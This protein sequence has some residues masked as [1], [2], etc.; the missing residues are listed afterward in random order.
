MKELVA[1]AQLFEALVEHG[2]QLKPQDS[3]HSGKHH[4]RFIGRMSRFF[5][6]CFPVNLLHPVTPAANGQSS[7]LSERPH[8]QVVP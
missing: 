4:A 7:P 6:Q 1:L 8:L 3:L 2:N 5:F